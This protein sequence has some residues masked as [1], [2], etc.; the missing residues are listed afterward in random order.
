LCT[1]ANANAII[2][3]AQ[4]ALLTLL[5]ACQQQ[6]LCGSWHMQDEII[7]YQE[8]T[9]AH[10]LLRLDSFADHTTKVGQRGKVAM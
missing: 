3:I 4:E 8:R 1:Y 10:R 6:P 5:L 2:D 7:K 9:G